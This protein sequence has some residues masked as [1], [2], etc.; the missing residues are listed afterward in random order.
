MQI[1]LP[2]RE[3]GRSTGTLFSPQRRKGRQERKGKDFF[4][5]PL[6]LGVLAA[7]ALIFSPDHPILSD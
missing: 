6:R 4:E 5:F 1:D 3:R 7:F 2:S